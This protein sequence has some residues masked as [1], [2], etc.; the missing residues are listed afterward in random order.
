MKRDKVIS[1][2]FCPAIELAT[3]G[4]VRWEDLRPDV[5]WDVLRPS[6]AI[7]PT[8]PEPQEASHA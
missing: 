7:T 6:G 4:A 2:D 8:H 1:S 3:N 5:R